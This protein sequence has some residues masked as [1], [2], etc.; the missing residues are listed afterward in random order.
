[1]NPITI[2]STLFFLILFLSQTTMAFTYTL[3][4]PEAELQKKIVGMMPLEKKKFF[5][6]ITLSDPVVEL[7]E[8]DNKVGVFTHIKV[9]GPKGIQGM[10]RTKITGSLSYES[11]KAEF[12][13][14]NMVIE[15]LEID[16]IQDKYIPKIQG[17]VQL[18]ARK[19]LAKRPVYRLKDNNVKHKLA[20]AVLESIK[21]KDKKL[22]VELSL[23]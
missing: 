14:K 13:F 12:F 19:M 8:R 20:K 21:V 7:I 2:R 3:E 6:T 15:N 23:F 9:V 4:I 17:I 1:M 5:F 10:G 11:E 18:V 16:K 22:W